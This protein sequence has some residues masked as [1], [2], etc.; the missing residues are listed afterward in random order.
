MTNYFCLCR[1]TRLQIRVANTAINVVL[2]AFVVTG[3]IIQISRGFI[4]TGVTKRT[5]RGF[6]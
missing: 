2:D 5:G 6:G 1:V 3:V 4:V